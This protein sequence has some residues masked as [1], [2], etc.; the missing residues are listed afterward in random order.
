MALGRGLK[1]PIFWNGD[2]TKTGRVEFCVQ[3][4][5]SLNSLNLV[6]AEA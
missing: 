6:I 4:R 3:D 5:L 1:L 2:E